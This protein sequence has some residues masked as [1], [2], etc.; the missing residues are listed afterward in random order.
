MKKL[1]LISCLI[2]IN[3]VNSQNPLK[4][5]FI[6]KAGGNYG[7][8][9][10]DIAQWKG[11]VSYMVGLACEIPITE[12]LSIQPEINFTR[13]LANSERTEIWP[14]NGYYYVTIEE[15]LRTSVIS[16]P[17]MVKYKIGEKFNLQ[18]GPQLNYIAA[19]ERER[20]EKYITD[21]PNA[22][23]KEFD[24]G[25]AFGVGFDLNSKFSI[26]AK[27]Y[28]GLMDLDKNPGTFNSSTNSDIGNMSI[29]S[30]NFGYKL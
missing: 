2:L 13:L 4:E 7:F 26:E 19:V 25:P 8:Y 28:Y 18:L 5:K 29:C 30:I 10:G 16:L 11:T 6:I 22:Y 12:K 27:Y 24:F 9:T 23:T 21:K 15:K 17:L 1:L 14:Y 3:S 20:P